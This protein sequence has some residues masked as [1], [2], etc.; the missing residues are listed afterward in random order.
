MMSLQRS[1]PARKGRSCSVS[2]A[3]IDATVA[4]GEP[5][6]HT[7]RCPCQLGPAMGDSR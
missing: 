4:V 2:K 5:V 3:L 6:S 1:A 7:R